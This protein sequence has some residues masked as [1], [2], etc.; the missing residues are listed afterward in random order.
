M[1]TGRGKN[2]SCDASRGV[3]FVAGPRGAPVTVNDSWPPDAG[4]DESA[5]SWPGMERRRNRK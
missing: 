4:V 5:I 3:E 2:L 1:K